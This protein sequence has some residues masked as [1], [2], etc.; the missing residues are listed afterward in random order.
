[1]TEAMAVG[2]LQVVR[3]DE[4]GKP[5]PIIRGTGECREI[6]GTRT[7]CALRS[8]YHVDL[9]QLSST[10]TLKHPG[11]AVYY[12]LEGSAEFSS[13]AGGMTVPAGGMVHVAPGNTYTISS[14][15][16]ARV[17]GGPA[18]VDIDFGADLGEDVESVRAGDGLRSFH[19]DEPGLMVPFISH[20]ARLVVWYGAAARSANMNYVVLEPG[21]RNKEHVHAY[22]EDT[23]FIV[24]GHGTAEDVTHGRKVPVGPGD[25]A[26]IPAGVWHAVAADRGERMVSVGGPCPADLDMLRAVGVDVEAIDRRNGG[27]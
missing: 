14:V 20:D 21:E 18:P 22:S 4:W 25:T 6:V 10:V 5:V 27:R 11:E 1:M 15:V 19:K 8:L 2:Q 12:V 9:G 26:T 3:R 13:A 23:I 7:G 16:G 24:E 17:L